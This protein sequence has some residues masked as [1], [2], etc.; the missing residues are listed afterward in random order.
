MQSMAG[1]KLL[2]TTAQ[3]TRGWVGFG[4]TNMQFS[5]S[6]GEGENGRKSV[7]RQGFRRRPNLS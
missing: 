6:R 1:P 2:A 3:M 5:P 4:L 7:I